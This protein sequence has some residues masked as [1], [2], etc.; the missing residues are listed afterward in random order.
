MSY[1]ACEVV[2]VQLIAGTAQWSQIWKAAAVCLNFVYKISIFTSFFLPHPKPVCWFLSAS[3]IYKTWTVAETAVFDSHPS[4][5]NRRIFIKH[6]AFIYCSTHMIGFILHLPKECATKVKKVFSVFLS[7]SILWNIL[8]YNLW[9]NN[10]SVFSTAVFLLS[11]LPSLCWIF[12]LLK[13]TLMI[14]N[15]ISVWMLH[16]AVLSNI[17]WELT[18][19]LFH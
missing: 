7:C 3:F 9:K 12:F 16:T 17:L 14:Q 4:W 18:H 11:V 6:K 19:P 1:A 15:H 8:E 2:W 10:G 5:D 13:G